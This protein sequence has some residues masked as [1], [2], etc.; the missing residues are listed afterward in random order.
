MKS[1]YLYSHFSKSYFYLLYQSAEADEGQKTP[2]ESQQEQSKDVEGK[3]GEKE[4]SP[5]SEGDADQQPSQSD[6]NDKPKEQEAETADD[7]TK[8]VYLICTSYM[9]LHIDTCLNCYVTCR[10]MILHLHAYTYFCRFSAFS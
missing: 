1:F 5:S 3:M 7:I 4:E 8:Q 2:D 9:C 10:C 6:K